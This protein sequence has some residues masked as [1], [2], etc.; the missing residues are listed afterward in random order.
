[1]MEGQNQEGSLH[2]CT[3]SVFCCRKSWQEL[4][5]RQLSIIPSLE[6]L[7]SELFW[8]QN[9]HL[10]INKVYGE[11]YE[12]LSEY[13]T[14][15]YLLLREDCMHNL[16]QG[17]QALSQNKRPADRLDL[18]IYWDARL[19]SVCCGKFGM[20]HRLCFPKDNFLVKNSGF[21]KCLREGSLICMSDDGFRSFFWCTVT[22]HIKA[23]IDGDILQIKVLEDVGSVKQ[24]VFDTRYTVMESPAAFFE[25]YCHVLRNLQKPEMNHLPFGEH[26]VF[27][28][29]QVDVPDYLQSRKHHEYDFFS[30]FPEMDNE[31]GSCAFS[32]LQPWPK[33]K[34]FLDPSQMEAVKHGI[35]RRLALIQGPPGTGKTFVGNVI[36]KILLNN[37]WR[38]TRTPLVTDFDCH[39]DKRM[40]IKDQDQMDAPLL[41][42]CYTNH[43]LDQFLEGVLEFE[44][45]LIRYGGRSTSSKLASCT[46]KQR[47]KKVRRGSLKSVWNKQRSLYRQFDMLRVEIARCHAILCLHHVTF[48]PLQEVATQQQMESLY[49]CGPNRKVIQLWLQGLD[50]QSAYGCMQIEDHENLTS[51]ANEGERASVLK[52]ERIEKFEGFDLEEPYVWTLGKS[53]RIAL[54]GEW[55]KRIKNNAEKR[56]CELTTEY[57]SLCALR[58]KLEEDIQ[59]FSLKAA[60]VVGMTTTAAARCHGILMRLKPKV[61][62]V[63]EAAEI[64][65][66]HI[67]SCLTPFTEHLILIGDHLQLRPSIAVNKLAA[68]HNLDVSLFERLV[69]GGVENVTLKYQRRMRPCISRLLRSVYPALKDHDS[70]FGRKNVEG[71]SKNVFFLDHR[72]QERCALGSRSKV[73]TEESLFIVEL[74]LYV[75]KQ[76][77]YKISDV[78]ILTMYRAQMECIKSLLQEKA[79]YS[80]SLPANVVKALTGGSAHVT[81]V[82]DF[83]GEESN[84]IILSL[85]RNLCFEKEVESIGFL[86]SSH[87]ICVALSRARDGLYILG[88]AD[89]LSSKSELWQA[90]VNDMRSTNAV[91]SFLTLVCH[92]HFPGLQTEIHKARD[93]EKV[94]D[95]GCDTVVK[96]DVHRVSEVRCIPSVANHVKESFPADISANLYAI[97][98]ASHAQDLAR[99]CAVIDGASE[100]VE[101]CASLVTSYANGTVN[102]SNVALNVI[103]CRICNPNT[104]EICSQLQLKEMEASTNFVELLDCGHLAEYNMLDDWVDT[105]M[106]AETGELASSVW[107]KSCP[108][109]KTPIRKTVRYL[110]VINS[111]LLQLEESKKLIIDN[112]HRACISHDLG[113]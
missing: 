104:V 93:F 22:R 51:I 102:T 99:M 61:V 24:L 80:H 68:D 56:L 14:T 45:N 18:Q 36:I 95:G 110:A 9:N 17:I 107:P 57:Q 100:N 13:L 82:D 48:E 63:E 67:I 53:S 39:K 21:S 40:K 8:Q 97:K 74:Y 31:I 34:S 77:F 27:L 88:N 29:P 26:L 37:L 49:F 43:A 73:N 79:E 25:A 64:L 38:L 101:I 54:H 103:R 10:P 98:H 23:S 55:L 112:N 113:T 35:T 106:P 84:I 11:K 86:E 58:T 92:N 90:V 1:M 6:E 59:Y 94:V 69:S 5:F 41:V 47:F 20:E 60:R 28:E 19:H 46:V 109:C 111:I 3:S 76:G 50:M 96:A 105:G 65:E 62:I 91:G 72:W 87:R 85:V 66:G 12:S 71:L 81:S 83:Q 7:F 44:E 78:T 89:L 42:L 16:C 2:A 75:L 108:Q 33:W 32:V 30:V 15:Q 52:E 70:V 4:D